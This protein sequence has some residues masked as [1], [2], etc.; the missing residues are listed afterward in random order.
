MKKRVIA[1]LLCMA[2]GL[3]LVACG[4]NDTATETTTD[5]AATEETAEE[6][7]AEE[8]T[9]EAPAEDAEATEAE[10][11][12]HL[13]LAINSGSPANFDYTTCASTPDFSWLSHMYEGLMKYGPSD[14]QITTNE[15]I[16]QATLQLG[17]AESYEYDEETYTY[18][19]HLRDNLFY[20]DGEPIEAEDFVYAFQRN[21]DPEVASAHASEVNGIIKNATEV[22]NGEVPV[23]ELGVSAPDSKTVVFELVANNP[24]FLDLCAANFAA[25]VRKEL[26][27]SQGEEYMA[28][29]ENVVSNGA[30]K[31]TEWDPGIQITLEKNEYYYDVENLGPDKITYND[32]TNE[33]TLLANYMADEWDFVSGTPAA[34]REELIAS[35]DLY[36]GPAIGL[37]YLYMNVENTPD[38]RVRAAYLLAI[39]RENIVNNVTKNGAIP[40]SGLIPAGCTNT[41]DG[42]EWTTYAGEPAPMYYWLSENYPD[43]DLS[44]YIGRCEL[45]QALYQ[46][47]VDDG[48]DTT[49]S[50]TIIFTN[51]E[52][53][54]AMAESIQT[55]LKNVLGCNLLIQ[56]Q[57]SGTDFT[58]DY[59]LGRLSL[60]AGSPDTFQFFGCFGTNGAFENSHW[61]SAA[62]DELLAEASMLPGG[63]ER[64]AA[65]LELERIMFSD[66]GF[67]HCPLYY[68]AYSFCLKDGISNLYYQPGGTVM[69]FM[70][71]TQE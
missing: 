30:Y 10:E 53:N 70:Y 32:C 71:A 61:S 59:T 35:G 37:T 6:A 12:F 63:A 56:G 48:F 39:D 22:Y 27:E 47:A 55:D 46:E 34:Q 29:L 68:S 4:G 24:S 23:E 36:S 26:V 67:G 20:S 14:V 41:E 33:T 5:N 42:T 51:S 15:D 44:D 28:T 45:A 13:Q 7:P 64:D 65:S 17:M 57:D 21:Q 52:V 16:H 19:F 1:S 50:P 66:E 3:S 9:E 60:S 49:T 25:P 62:Y 2:M 58:Q 11:E 43:Y 8:T 38:W 54:K 31:L 69:H 18:T 40:A